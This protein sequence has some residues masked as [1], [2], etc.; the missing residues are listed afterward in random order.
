RPVPLLALNSLPFH[1][2]AA[3][4]RITLLCTKRTF[5]TFR[6]HPSK[7]AL[8][9]S[10]LHPKLRAKLGVTHEGAFCSP[11][12][13]RFNHFDICRRFVRRRN[14]LH[15]GSGARPLSRDGRRRATGREKPPNELHTGNH[16]RFGRLLSDFEFAGWDV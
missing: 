10:K 13:N 15:P 6:L 8:T 16:F 12:F 11:V 4:N 14:R 5:L 3:R 7:S 2:S 9:S 1:P